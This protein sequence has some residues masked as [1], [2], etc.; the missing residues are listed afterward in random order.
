MLWKEMKIFWAQ[1][2][3]SNPLSKTI[4]SSVWHIIPVLLRYP[5]SLFCVDTELPAD[6]WSDE[7]VEPTPQPPTDLESA[8]RQIKRL[9]QQLVQSQK[10]LGDYRTF[11]SERLNLAS[12][13]EAL[14]EPES[15]THAAQPLRDDDSHYFQSYGDNGPF[16]NLMPSSTNFS[17]ILRSRH[18]RHHDPGQSPNRNLRF[19]HT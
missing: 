6:D 15:S 14:K 12:L 17:T 1:T 5:I 11:V 3:T 2:N 18:P 8:K 10:D 16:L 4:L 19:I 13:A 9:Q 7:E